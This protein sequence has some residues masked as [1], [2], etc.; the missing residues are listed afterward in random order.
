MKIANRIEH[1]LLRPESNQDAVRHLCMAAKDMQIAAI[2]IPPAWAR[3]ASIAL[4]DSTVR[5]DVPVGYPLGTHTAST[6]GLEA[7]LALEEGA[8]EVTVVPNL[9]FYLSGWRERFHQDLDYVAKQARQANPEVVIRALLYLDLVPEAQYGEIVKVVRESGIEFQFLASYE[10]ALASAPM[11]ERISALNA[12]G[13]SLGVWGAIR[14][15]DE[16]RSLFGAG[17]ARLATPYG[18]DLVQEAAQG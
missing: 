12:I 2:G 1:L 3:F 4:V 17:V 6:K 14:S 8:Q 5:L 13:V 18:L 7:R 15:L 11:I 10:Q 9:A 16:A